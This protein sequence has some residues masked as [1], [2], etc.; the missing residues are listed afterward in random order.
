VPIFTHL[1]PPYLFAFKVKFLYP[2]LY[3]TM[4]FT[5]GSTCHLSTT[6]TLKMETVLF[7]VN[8]IFNF[9]GKPDGKRTLRRPRHRLNKNVRMDL[10]K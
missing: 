2:A 10:E 8:F 7:I 4:L 6:S 9:G 3:I 1:L 5:S